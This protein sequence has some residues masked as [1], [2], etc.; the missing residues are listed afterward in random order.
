MQQLKDLIYQ[1]AI[2][3]GS[4]TIPEIAERTGVSTTTISKH[5]AEMVENGVIQ[6]VAHEDVRR[7]G[8]KAVL[9]SIVEKGR[10]FL[11][12]DIKRDGLSIGVMNVKGELVAK[13]DDPTFRFENTHANLD[14]VCSKVDAF[15]SGLVAGP[16]AGKIEIAWGAFSISG[17]VDSKHGVS[18]SRY[19][20]EETRDTPLAEIL[21]EKF[22]FPV[23]IENDTKAM[24]WGE[25]LAQDK[26][27]QNMLY[28]N[29]GWGLGLGLILDGKLY[30]GSQGFSG[31]L[32]HMPV[33]S[34][35]ILCHCGKKGCM[36]TEVSGLAIHRKLL[37]RIR[38]GESSVLSDKVRKGEDITI[39][40]IIDATE[41]E[42][43]LCIE[44][45]SATGTE[46]GRQLAGIIN[47][48]NPDC[49]VVGGDLSNA[50][51]YYFLQQVGL[52]IKQH[53]L[54]LLS[55]RVAVMTSV[56]GDDAGVVGACS[57][58]REKAVDSYSPNAL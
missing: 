7:K 14:L 47:L 35:G 6:A 53:S 40:D 9:Y 15:L 37:E 38:R 44:L 16:D 29:I 50:A 55:Q 36:E 25:Y 48:L 23:S 49:I 33:Y 24:A 34:N 45:V 30:G 42:D 39:R 46:L 1:S 4:F 5:V 58:A 17:R 32:G 19:N 2:R 43:P 28:V 52:A 3:D 11:G 10:C 13:S 12:V 56:L 27:W 8:R 18:A 20:F 41:R 51:S 54:K 22:G 26:K 21:T 31:E 57:L